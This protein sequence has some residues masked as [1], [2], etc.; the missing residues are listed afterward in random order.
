VSQGET[1]GLAVTSRSVA[2]P[3]SSGEILKLYLL[4]MIGFPTSCCSEAKMPNVL[5][6]RWELT[7]RCLHH[8]SSL[9]QIRERAYSISSS[10]DEKMKQLKLW[11]V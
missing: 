2:D 4:I 8:L 11:S 9:M 5:I 1:G 6:F 10:A 7:Q 3:A